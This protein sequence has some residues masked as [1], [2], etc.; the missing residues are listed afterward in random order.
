LFKQAT[1]CGVAG[2]CSEHTTNPGASLG[3]VSRTTGSHPNEINRKTTAAGRPERARR[4]LTTEGNVMAETA[5]SNDPHD[6]LVAQRI[7]QLHRPEAYPVFDAETVDVHETHISWVFLV[8][9]YAYK[10]KKPIKLDFLDYSTAQRRRHFCEQELRLDRR[11]AADLYLDVVP[12][13]LDGDRL[14]VEGDGVAVDYAVKMHRFDED[15]LLSA[16]L[17]AG[18][19]T[20]A[21]VHAL[22]EEV[23]DFHQRAA[24]VDEA[25]SKRRLRSTDQIHQNAMDNLDALAD[26]QDHNSAHTVRVLKEWTNAY[27]EDFRSTFRGRGEGG[28]IRE[29]HGD[30]HLANVVRWRDQWIPFDGIEFNEP[31]RWIDVISDAAFAAMDFAA[32]GRFDFCNSFIN[33]YLECTGDHASLEVLRWYLVYRATTRSKVARISGQ[34]AERGSADRDSAMKAC[35]DYL[36]LAYRFSLRPEPQLWI[37]H[38]VSGSGKTT[39]S[40]SLVQRYGAIRL[41]SDLERKRH[42][43]LEPTDRPKPSQQDEIYGPEGTQATYTRLRRLSRCILHAGFP[44]VVDATFLKREHRELFR[45]LARREGAR[46]SILHC[47]ADL[48]TLRR[49]VSE[50][51][52]RGE[53]ASDADLSVL[54]GQ[55]AAEEP[56]DE[57]ERL[58]TVTTEELAGAT[59]G[60]SGGHG[61]VTG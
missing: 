33:T 47:D 28:F 55:L 39:A 3:T 50:R 18:D 37:T 24:R 8:G 35:R 51:L 16:R 11:Y 45:N 38:G 13:T 59:G 53:D 41:R 6:R 20:L 48:P 5:E 34:Q 44:V 26:L 10:V 9:P 43:G 56:L 54:Q 46:F 36:E 17:D 42:F 15:A 49:R 29:C 61:A 21:D 4:I 27:F 57:S 19:V 32:R 40:E 60:E 12:I 2:G 22:A 52:Q 25:S 23:A 7:D 31:F 1:R 58:H 14:V 30:L